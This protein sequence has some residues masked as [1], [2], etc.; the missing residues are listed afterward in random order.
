[1]KHLLI[2]L[3]V[4][5]IALFFSCNEDDFIVDKDNFLI[6]NW[7]FQKSTESYDRTTYQ[8]KRTKNFSERGGS[9]HLGN[10]SLYQYRGSW[11]FGMQPMIFEGT[12][13]SINDTLIKINLLV[14]D[15]E[16]FKL[17]VNVINKDE[18]HYYYIYN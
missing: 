14:P 7:E 11:G 4:L 15:N 5:M 16:V 8:M 6:G 17:V 12:W 3:F 2:P 1:M 13:S 9:I 10:D 18:L